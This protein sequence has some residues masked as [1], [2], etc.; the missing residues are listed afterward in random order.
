VYSE[1]ETQKMLDMIN[2]KVRIVEGEEH[3]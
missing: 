2:Q 3:E 1:S